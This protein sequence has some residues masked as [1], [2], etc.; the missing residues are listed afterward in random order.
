MIYLIPHY[1]KQ[2]QC[3]A[4]TCPDTCCAGWEI[5]IDPKSLKQYQETRGPLGNRLHNSINWDRGVFYQYHHRCAFLNEENLCDLQAEG[6]ERMLCRTCRIYPRHVEEFE[7]VREISLSLS[8]IEAARII[9][10]TREPVRFLSRE[11][12]GKEDNFE[13]FDY[14]LYT[15]LMD[16]RDLIFKILQNRNLDLR[17]RMA[18]V[19]SLAH[20]IQRRIFSGHLFQVDSLL[21]RYGSPQAAARFEKRVEGMGFGPV[22][23][24]AA[25]DKGLE[26]LG[27]MEVL[28]PSWSPRLKAIQ[29]ALYGMG[30][31]AY[32]R[33]REEF[34][35][36]L[37]NQ[38]KLDWQI[39]GEQLMVYF[40]YTYY[41][42][43]VY[44]ERAYT[45][46]KLGVYSTLVIQELAF[47]VW[48][49]RNR[50]LSF[51]D[52]ADM[53]H[54][55]SREVEH[56]DPNKELLMERLEEQWDYRMEN[57]VGMTV[58]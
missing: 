31:G 3:I 28:N 26:I 29:E 34:L 53:A 58:K 46:M 14:F 43:A 11:R 20:D 48:I 17:L 22:R 4:G 55:F 24:F 9:L 2:F 21:E 41:C 50:T 10:G 16:S 1:Y 18:M 36:W 33:K 12:Q 57:L 51:D 25:M 19:L 54:C 44:D 13:D 38:E 15:K 5:A 45:R 56:S 39:L 37:K 35:Q 7:G 23:R 8:C 47:G 49:T 30:P 52:F 42:G 32:E 27:R 40:V 6:G